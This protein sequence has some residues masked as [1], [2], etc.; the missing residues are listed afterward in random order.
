VFGEGDENI[1]RAPPNVKW[2]AVLLQHSRAGKQS[3]RSK[4]NGR[5]LIV[6]VWHAPLPH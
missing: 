5:T 6:L 2:S 1:E 3:E 4:S